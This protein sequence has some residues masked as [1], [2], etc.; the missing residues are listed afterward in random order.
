M[1]R[2][3][4]S[5]LKPLLCCMSLLCVQSAMATTAA[6]TDKL[7]SLRQQ[8]Q[9]PVLAVHINSP[10]QADF[11]LVLGA[12]ASTPLRWGSIT[13]TITALTILTLA[14]QGKLSLLAPLHQYSDTKHW[15]NP[16][17]DTY[18]IRLIDLLEMRAGFPDLSAE[19]FAFNEPISLDQ[20]LALNPRH[21]TSRWPPGTRHVYSNMSAG[22]TQLLIETV[23][24]QPYA[25]AARQLVLEQ[26]AMQQAGFLPV[27]ELPGGFK[28]DGQT[29]I[30]YWHMT[31]P[32]YGALNA[33]LHDMVKL[34]RY[35][36]TPGVQ[37][38]MVEAHLFT[39]HGRR[40][41]A[42]F[43]F[44]YAAGLY[45]RIRQGQVWHTHGGDADGY[46]SRLAL[47]PDGGGYV[48][49]INTDNPRA[50]RQI[51]H[52]LETYLTQRLPTPEAPPTASLSSAEIAAI[53]GS[54][55]PSAVRFGVTQWQQGNAAVIQLHATSRVVSVERRGQTTL[56]Y[57]VGPGLFRRATD[58]V[59]T[60]TI[61]AEQGT[62]HIQGE[63]GNHQQ[64]AADT[65][66]PE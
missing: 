58:P 6:L 60:V 50:L 4:S 36:Q 13:K 53:S 31:F 37:P 8:H 51:E 33:S 35:L 57:P 42:D 12:Q 41:A 11:E 20:A 52:E 24:Q 46:R 64:V 16:W 62:M 32:A 18:P 63:L 56:L 55:Y 27:A 29:E 48:A 66:T 17:R 9:I 44:D 54:Y 25:A 10:S 34:L 30:P 14:E 26:L 7:K 1:M 19:E 59:A 61:F 21:R 22:L 2:K 15:A 65:E 39:P 47:L 43:N 49:N 38:A 40:W 45:P 28:A 5:K 3:V 23:T